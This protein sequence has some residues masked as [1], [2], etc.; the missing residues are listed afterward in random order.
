MQNHSKRL[1][2]ISS[3]ILAWIMFLSSACQAERVSPT[4]TTSIQPTP[5]INTA[6]PQPTPTIVSNL[7]PI[8]VDAETLDGTQ[9]SFWHPW[10][11]ATLQVINDLTY[12]FNI[13]NIWGVEVTLAPQGSPRHLREK[14]EDNLTTSNLPNVIAAP[15]DDL[16]E[17]HTEKDILVPLQNYIQQPGWGLSGEEI[18]SYVPDFWQQETFD[19]SQVGIPAIRS[20]DLLFYNHTWAREMGFESPPRT[21]QEFNEQVCSA[22]KFNPDDEDIGGYILDSRHTAILNWLNV[23]DSTIT[24]RL[25]SADYTFDKP[26]VK[27]AVTFLRKMVDAG[28]AWRSRLPLPYEYFANRQALVYSGDMQDILEQTRADKKFNNQ[29]EWSIIPFP[30]NEDKQSLIV[31]GL[32]YAML[33]S[34]PEEQLASW[35]FMRWLTL[36]QNHARLVQASGTLPV[37]TR[38]MEFLGSFSQQN[39]NWEKFVNS[40]PELKSD[41]T[42]P[43]WRTVRMILSDAV[44][45]SLQYYTEPSQIPILMLQ[46]DAMIKE[47][48]SYQP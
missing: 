9:V 11:G 31:N 22:A 23:F 19:G 2:K 3:F 6:T 20:T 17:L 32:S 5:V 8:E 29:D 15:V 26:S 38:E 13:N 18:A 21:P 1:N 12:E 25:S 37:T 41:P 14:I 30:S 7:D 33:N 46:L 28:C 4:P 45:Q 43:G 36:P 24:D 34:S 48:L 47:V 39:P 16:R 42:A 40:L 10:S 27:Q 44:W 35:L